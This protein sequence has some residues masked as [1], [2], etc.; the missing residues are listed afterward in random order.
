MNRAKLNYWV[1]LAIAV[2][3]AVS[4]LSGL[5]FL[6]PPD[7]AGIGPDGFPRMLGL[8]LL[9]WSDLHAISSLAMIAG[10]G[11]HLALHG[12]WIGRM[13]KCV[14]DRPVRAR[15][16]Y[17]VDVAIAISLLVSAVSGGLFLLPPEASVIGADGY[18]RLLGLKLTL[19]SDLHVIS[20]MVM[21]AGIGLHLAL[22]ARWIQQM[23]RCVFKPSSKTPRKVRRGDRCTQTE[24]VPASRTAIGISR[25]R[26]VRLGWLGLVAAAC[27]GTVFAAKELF[28]QQISTKSA[29]APEAP[30]GSSNLAQNTLPTQ[31]TDSPT[32]SPTAT[33]SV[34]PTN[35]S[36]SV[37]EEAAGNGR[38]RRGGRGT[39][40][41][42]ADQEN[43]SPA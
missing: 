21:V 24:A 15:R 25:R 33:P 42:S 28:G 36:S 43:T 14:S 8:T 1:D 41:L 11:A 32:A 13:T 17:W 16:N 7:M 37:V 40:T 39:E 35:A 31:A 38:R 29:A 27:T 26:F 23:T 30:D 3:T 6:L 5:V 12:Q 2:A 20:S 34:T 19:W 4:L 10:V 22:H 9:A 18:P